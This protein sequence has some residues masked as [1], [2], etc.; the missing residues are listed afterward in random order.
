MWKCPECGREFKN[1]NQN[2]SCGVTPASVD[3]Y[4]AVQ[5][6]DVQSILIKVRETIGVAVVS[7][8]ASHAGR[9]LDEII[10]FME[11]YADAEL[12]EVER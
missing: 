11:E 4:I 6:A 10:R 7:G 12:T 8:D 9:S 1:T 2:H 5:S 3:E